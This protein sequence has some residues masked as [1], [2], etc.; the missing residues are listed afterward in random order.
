MTSREN[1]ECI[2]HAFFTTQQNVTNTSDNNDRNEDMN[3]YTRHYA[4]PAA[5]SA[6][7]SLS[8]FLSLLLASS[9]PPRHSLPL[10]RD[11]L[12]LLR[13]PKRQV[14][15]LYLYLT[16]ERAKGGMGGQRS[17]YFILVAS[18]VVLSC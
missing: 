17:R 1:F 14:F 6:T 4:Q 9:H 10:P 2:F 16:G 5:V 8:S 7:A 3:V 15:E 18:I 13:L 12:A 11:D